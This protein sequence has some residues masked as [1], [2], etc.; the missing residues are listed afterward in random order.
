MSL[1]AQTLYLQ[2]R[3]LLRRLADDQV[4]KL[5]LAVAQHTDE[6]SCSCV[7]TLHGHPNPH[8]AT[9]NPRQGDQ[10]VGKAFYCT[11]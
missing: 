8:C 6:V 4:L 11:R 5:L 1:R 9:Q 3:D 7:A 10:S 2:H